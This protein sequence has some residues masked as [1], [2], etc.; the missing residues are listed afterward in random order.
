MAGT[1]LDQIQ[2]LLASQQTL[3]QQLAS[4]SQQSVVTNK[5]LEAYM[6]Q[7]RK[8]KLAE[9]AAK[10][11]AEAAAAKTAKPPRRGTLDKYSTS[12]KRAKRAPALDMTAPYDDRADICLSDILR[13]DQGQL[14]GALLEAALKFLV[15]AGRP[16]GEEHILEAA[17]SL[18]SMCRDGLGE[19]RTHVRH[20]RASPA[21]TLPPSAAAV[22][23]STV[24]DVNV[25]EYAEHALCFEKCALEATK[26]LASVV[27]T[28][29]LGARIFGSLLTA[30]DLPAKPIA[31]VAG[32]VE[33]TEAVIDLLREGEDVPALESDG[34]SR[35]LD[36]LLGLTYTKS[37]NVEHSVCTQCR[38]LGSKGDED[39]FTYLSGD[40]GQL[41]PCATRPLGHR[42]PSCAPTQFLVCPQP[43]PHSRLLWQD[44]DR[45]TRDRA[46]DRRLRAPELHAA[47]Q[48]SRHCAARLHLHL[49]LH[50]RT[51]P[52]LARARPRSPSAC[53]LPPPHPSRA[54]RGACAGD[55]LRALHPPRAPHH[56]QARGAAGVGQGTGAQRHGDQVPARRGPAGLTPRPVASLAGPGG[57]L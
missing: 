15:E 48:P 53:A 55:C 50:P 2:Q 21:C 27:R 20:N 32:A 12:N 6:V 13:K 5:R 34:A 46:G 16:M 33:S 9:K 37:D 41:H 31:P 44:C 22:E 56:V 28:K 1:S 17:I 26:S 57:A 35:Q 52:A 11:A 10:A 7:E 14:A 30:F 43:A 47:C 23:E 18:P 24:G 36:E 39:S 8:D 38:V 40:D 29:L 54:L 49:H 51:R 4:Q 3:I 25:L 45:V 42:A 19:L